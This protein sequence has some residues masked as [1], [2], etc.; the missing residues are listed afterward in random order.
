M[1]YVILQVYTYNGEEGRVYTGLDPML[2]KVK[3]APIGS[4]PSRGR[5]SQCI[6]QGLAVLIVENK[7]FRKLSSQIDLTF[8]E[9]YFLAGEPSGVPHRNSPSELKENGFLPTLPP[10]FF[11]WGI[12]CMVLEKTCWFYAIQSVVIRKNL[13]VSIET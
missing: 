9:F 12:H 5:K 6:R 1:V 10:T 3:Q 13:A 4:N 7:N 2:M 11:R 8:E